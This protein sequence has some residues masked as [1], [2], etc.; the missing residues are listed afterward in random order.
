MNGDLKTS[1]APVTDA[2]TRVLILG[3]LPGDASLSA[4]RYYAHPRN[5]FWRLMEGVT[6]Q[7]LSAQSYPARLDALRAAGVGLWDVIGSAERAGSLD[8][9]IRRH[10]ANPLA[11]LAARL[12]AL[13]AIGFNGG[14]AFSLGR[15]LFGEAPIFDL[16]PLPSS[17]PAHAVSFERKLEAWVGLR[18]YLA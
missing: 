8:G 18:R 13:R 7:D 3:S 14:K 16:V 9:A 5:Q 6:D 4:G 11:E 15:R 2:E 12:P 10:T 17:S 1:F